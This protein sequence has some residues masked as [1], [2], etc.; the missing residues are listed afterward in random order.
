MFRENALKRRLAA[1]K[2]ALGCWLFSGDPTAAEIIGHA[3]YDFVLID[4]EHGPGDPLSAVT[5]LRALSASPSTVLM[6]VAW[7]DPVRIKRALDI[8][9]E[10]IMVPM[11][12]TADQAR[13]AV[14]ACRYPPAGLR[15][16]ASSVVRASDY[17]IADDAYLARANDEIVVMCQ[18]ESGLAVDNVAEIAA[19]DGVDVLFIGPNDLAASVGHPGDTMHADS[20]ALI[21]R[22][23][24]AIQAAGAK[25]AAV[26]Y[27][28][29]NGAELFA[30][31][32]DLIPT[33][34]D[35]TLLRDGALAAV[36]AHREME[37]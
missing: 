15:G 32:Y 5:L 31:G 36:A 33:N 3:G 30:R 28:G 25:M 37:D 35:I 21:T 14:A 7:N 34:S 27:G 6:R 10:G 8:G 4:H 13:A 26:P 12:E 17:G 19:V 20:R 23:E 16:C 9:V 29:M 24:D 11:V 1:G 2:K 22:A 18:I